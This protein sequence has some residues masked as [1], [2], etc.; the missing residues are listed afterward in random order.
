MKAANNEFLNTLK[1]ACGAAG[2]VAVSA[3]QFSKLQQLCKQAIATG[4]CTQ[5]EIAVMKEMKLV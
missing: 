4:K 3:A 1:A 5:E 2:N